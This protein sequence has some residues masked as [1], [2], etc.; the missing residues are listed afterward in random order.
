MN[1]NWK[2]DTDSD[3]EKKLKQL[4][5]VNCSVRL[6][7]RVGKSLDREVSIFEKGKW[8]YVASVL[9][10]AAGAVLGFFMVQNVGFDEMDGLGHEVTTVTSSKTVGNDFED[11][12]FATVLADEQ[13][14]FIP[15]RATGYLYEIK[16]EGVVFLDGVN[17]A[18]EIYL[19][20]L[21]VVEWRDH[22]SNMTVRMT[23]PKQE[24]RVVPINTF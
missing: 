10:F 22:E 3:L 8:C 19:N 5:P 15:M 6:E 9:S 4:S 14:D 17:P 13:S 24:L 12:T 7:E 1:N 21:E 16:D 18:R 23:S 11:A 20:Y 2:M